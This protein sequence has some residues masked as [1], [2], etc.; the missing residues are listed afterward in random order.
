MDALNTETKP[1]LPYPKNTFWFWEVVNVLVPIIGVL[2]FNWDIFSI[3]YLFW[4]E[5]LLWGAVGV[6]QMITAKGISG[7]FL[8]R[9]F[10]K[11][12]YLI[13]YSILYVGLFTILFSFTF[14]E[15]ET[16]TILDGGKGIGIGLVILIINY[17]IDFIRSEIITQRFRIRIP[18]EVIFERFMYAL[19]LSFL[20]LFAVVPLA[21]KFDGKQIEKVIAIGIIAVKFIMSIAAYYLPKV[22]VTEEK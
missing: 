15:L 5:V 2:F 21:N 11:I 4:I 7:G 16:S 19:P 1:F 20:I 12:G 3:I 8:G 17:F 9:T 10:N 22:M 6:L 13:F 18:L 14:I